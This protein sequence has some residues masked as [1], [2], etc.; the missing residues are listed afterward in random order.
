MLDPSQQQIDS[1]ASRN[2][3]IRR[4]LSRLIVRRELHAVSQCSFLLQWVEI[5]RQARFRIQQDVEDVG[6]ELRCEPGVP[7]VL[8]VA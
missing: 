4:L 2:K 7:A 8:I 3:V 1:A 5:L 6:A